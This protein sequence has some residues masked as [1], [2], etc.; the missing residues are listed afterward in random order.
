MRQHKSLPWS[1][2]RAF[3]QVL[4]FALEVAP[5]QALAA[6]GVIVRGK[7]VRAWNRLC[8]LAELHWDYYLFWSEHVSTHRKREFIGDARPLASLAV[9]PVSEESV[10]TMNEVL[11]ELIRQGHEWAVFK[12]EGTRLDPDIARV[13][14]AAVQRFPASAIFY[15]DEEWLLP[16]GTLMP[17]IKPD[18]SERLHMARNCLTGASAIRLTDARAALIGR[19]LVPSDRTGVVV[20]ERAVYANGRHPRHLPLVLT[21]R[22]DP[23]LELARWIE[24]APKIWSDWLFCRHPNGIP[25]LRATPPDPLTWPTVSIVIP[26]R[27]GIDLIRTCLA[28]IARTD[29]PG[30]IEVLIVDNG[31]VEPESLAYF[32]EA[33]VSGAAR[34]LRDDRP[35]NFSQLNNLAAA[36]ASGEFLCLLNN[37]VEA[38]DSEWLTVM[39]RFAVQRDVGAVGARLLYPDGTIQH[40]GVAIGVGNA[41][42]HIQRGVNPSS[43]EHA[44]WH[45]VTREV[46]AVTAACLLVSKAN[47]LAVGGF[48]EI[49][50]KVAFNDVDFCLKLDALGLANVYCA[51]AF[52]IHAESR[53]RPDD[54]RPDQIARFERELE[55]LQSRWDTRA[56]ADP[57][58]SPLLSKSSEK[59]VLRPT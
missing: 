25:F 8:S 20:L 46:T 22:A 4:R 30:G 16:D 45:A 35:F 14:M 37:D 23:E 2:W 7:R 27:D 28:G 56:F 47:Y 41:A 3:R 32:R 38:L 53:S 48:D 43:K 57:R 40:A 36:A 18:W 42:G 51:E 26:T 1:S 17:W 13:V 34:V 24:L 10:E 54:Y 5:L 6:L 33:E 9:V 39:I 59:C 11:D 50:F 15:W 29:Y 31:S 19:D 44:G 58:F 49:G 52:L 12:T 55:L 21:R